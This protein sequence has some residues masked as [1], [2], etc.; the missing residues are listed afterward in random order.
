MFTVKACF[1]IN[2]VYAQISKKDKEQTPPL[3]FGAREG[4]W[5]NAGTDTG[6]GA[7]VQGAGAQMQRTGGG[8][9]GG[10]GTDAG[11]RSVDATRKR[12]GATAAHSGSDGRRACG[13]S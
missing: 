5:G 2:T 9:D 7:A 13:G 8:V 3:A 12:R 1:S 4:R 6:G 11:A 10:G